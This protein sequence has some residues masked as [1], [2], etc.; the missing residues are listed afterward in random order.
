MIGKVTAVVLPSTDALR[1]AVLH[2]ASQDCWFEVTPLS[3]DKF[4]LVVKHE[5]EDVLPELPK[6]RRWKEFT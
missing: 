6:T 1:A 3:G 4:E 5:R 2:A